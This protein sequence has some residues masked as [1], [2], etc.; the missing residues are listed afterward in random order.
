[1][2][3]DSVYDSRANFYTAVNAGAEPVIKPKMNSTGRS[4]GSYTRAQTVREFLSD[5]KAWKKKH[6]YG[7]R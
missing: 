7:Q 1:M 6:M 2:F 3:G 4:R 5:P